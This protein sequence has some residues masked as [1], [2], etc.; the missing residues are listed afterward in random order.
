MIYEN[1]RYKNMKE[2]TM[3]MTKRFRNFSL[4]TVTVL[5]LSYLKVL[6]SS[7]SYDECFDGESLCYYTMVVPAIIAMALVVYF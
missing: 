2:Y 1:F 7:K 5:Y 3:R 4:L 6:M